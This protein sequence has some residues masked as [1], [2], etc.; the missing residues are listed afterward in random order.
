MRQTVPVC[1]LRICCLL[2]CF[3]LFSSTPNFHVLDR[4]SDT[5]YQ[6]QSQTSIIGMQQVFLSATTTSTATATVTDDALSSPSSSF[7]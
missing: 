6:L 5:Y 4:T 3:S 1:G 2:S 7:R